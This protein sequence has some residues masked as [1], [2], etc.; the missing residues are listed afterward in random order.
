MEDNIP[1]GHDLDGSI[2][3]GFTHSKKLIT[4]EQ[5]QARMDARRDERCEDL[6]SLMI[7]HTHQMEVWERLRI[8]ENDYLRGLDMQDIFEANDGGES[9]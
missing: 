4:K 7:E 5:A 1:F 8:S 6:E 3:E 9:E 2:K